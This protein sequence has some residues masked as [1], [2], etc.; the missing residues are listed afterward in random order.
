MKNN[1]ISTPHETKQRQSVGTS[2]ARSLGAGQSLRLL[3]GAVTISVACSRPP[4]A[5]PAVVSETAGID[6]D[7]PLLDVAS[8]VM[9]DDGGDAP[10]DSA[11]DTQSDSPDTKNG[12]SADAKLDPLCELDL[13]TPGEP[14]A[15]IGE[16]R[17]TNAGAFVSTLGA[18]FCSRPNYLVCEPD[19]A[20]KQSWRIDSCESATPTVAFGCGKPS[21]MIWG[22]AHRCQPTT[23]HGEGTNPTVGGTKISY[24]GTVVCPNMH[25]VTNCGGSYVEGCRS[26]EELGPLAADVKAHFPKC[27]QY[28]DMGY[29]IFPTVPCGYKALSCPCKNKNPPPPPAPM[30]A[31]TEYILQCFVDP[32]DNQP[33][34]QKTCK[35]VGAEGY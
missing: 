12:S 22:A 26:L 4:G 33:K 35:A 23:F 11:G 18:G 24:G 17:C 14:C 25:G 30:C 29:Y 15:K 9:Q 3:F 8:L 34:C 7:V 13:P 31:K 21:C 27:G 28:L 2:P 10:M 6:A 32:A 5:A 1:S 16:I 20:G 19:E